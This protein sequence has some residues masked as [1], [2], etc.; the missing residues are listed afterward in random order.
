MKRRLAC[1]LAATPLICLLGFGLSI[2]QDFRVQEIVDGVY[3]VQDAVS[4]DEQLIIASDKGLV[5]L[6][7]FWSETTSRRFKSEIVKALK[8]DDFYCLVNT[9]DRLDMF[10]GNA[11]Y[12]DVPIIGHRAFWDKYQ[13][14]EVEV[15]AEIDRLVAMWRWKEDVAQERMAGH[16]PGSQ[17]AMNEQRWINMCKTRAD[18]L[19]SGFSLVLP[20]EVYDDTRTLDLG[21][22]T[23]NLI[24]LGRAG[25]DGMTVIEI[26]E[27]KTAIVSGFILHS[28]HL[29]PYPQ[30]EFAPLDVPR[31]INVLES[32]LEGDGAV[33]NVLCGFGL[34]DLWSRERAHTHL[35]Y[36][37]ELWTAVTE[38]E[39][40][41]K[42]LP[43]ISRRLS[44]DSAF[45]FVKEMQEYKDRGDDWIRPQHDGHVR[46]FFLQHK[47]PASEVIKRAGADS[48]AIAVERVRS[49]K[50][51]GSDI[52]IE[53]AAINDIGYY[54]LGEER[55]DD[56]VEV[57]RLN[58]DFF[59]QSFNAY[60]SYAEALMRSGDIP[61][62]IV[63]YGKSLEL[64]PENQNARTVIDSLR[65]L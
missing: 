57:L 4:G 28:H 40:E 25:Y 21:D 45:S 26:P 32:L 13:G 64:N 60:D 43:E 37:R 30:Q 18:E 23:L 15:R 35:H 61:S 41:G 16:E 38:A 62:A 54:L 59:P 22:M 53:E 17:A 52:Y 20:T 58:I 36:I 6:N 27:R 12:Q 9:V 7:S 39:A 56:A 33:D 42:D 1:L 46:L 3:A 29:A 2:A 11:A 5:V 63:N 10:G 48:V 44:L 19:E 55:F 24:W 49:L 34:T 50:K 8:R 65:K 31:W 51:A 14:K 47:N